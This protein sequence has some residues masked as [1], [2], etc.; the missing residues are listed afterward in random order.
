MPPQPAQAT[1]QAQWKKGVSA[2]KKIVSISDQ[3]K[4]DLL[5][6]EHEVVIREKC[7]NK[8]MRCYNGTS[9]HVN[10]F[11][12]NEVTSF[13]LILV[14]VTTFIAHGRQKR[15]AS[16]LRRNIANF[17]KGPSYKQTRDSMRKKNHIF[18][19]DLVKKR[20]N[21]VT[22][23]DWNLNLF[24]PEKRGLA[25]IFRGRWSRPTSE[26]PKQHQRRQYVNQKKRKVK[27]HLREIWQNL[28]FHPEDSKRERERE[29]EREKRGQNSIFP[30]SLTLLLSSSYTYPDYVGLHP[31]FLSLHS[32]QNHT[33]PPLFSLKKIISNPINF[34][35]FEQSPL[36][37]ATPINQ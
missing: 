23:K 18:T 20:E 7:D 4:C 2:F 3:K 21:F 33:Q 1:T 30:L 35:K 32:T 26:T 34:T 12:T 6:S 37:C 11:Q 17:N 28:S 5:A 31:T 22:S 15:M 8:W 27:Q 19:H 16:P 29:R 36:Q 14:K 24:N 25:S 9:R 13:G 10:T